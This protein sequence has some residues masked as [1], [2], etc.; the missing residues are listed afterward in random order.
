MLEYASPSFCKLIQTDID[1]LDRI[2]NRIHRMICCDNSSCN[3]FPSLAERRSFLSKKLFKQIVK[4]KNHVLHCIL[5]RRLPSGRHE[6]PFC[7]TV[8]RQNS[9]IVHNVLND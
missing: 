2:Q 3:I 1:K 5:P 6:I 9:F 8:R 7:N 4:D